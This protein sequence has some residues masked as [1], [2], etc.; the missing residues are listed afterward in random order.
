MQI[1]I[2]MFQNDCLS[3][4]VQECFMEYEVDCVQ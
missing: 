3:N 1:N 2:Y 4:D